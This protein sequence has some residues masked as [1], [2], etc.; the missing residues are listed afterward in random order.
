MGLQF[1]M[2]SLLRT[3]TGRYE[4]KIPRNKRICSFCN[5][6]KIEAENH[7][8]LDCEAYSKIRDQSLGLETYFLQ[9]R[10]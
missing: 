5:S 2:S 8:L 3:E 9:N 7:F 1:S 4:I 6:N 10:T